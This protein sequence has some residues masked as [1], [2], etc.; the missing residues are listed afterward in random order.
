MKP[1]KLIMNAF[2]SYASRQEVDFSPLN[3]GGLFLITGPTGAGKTT[4]FDAMTFA[5]FGCASSEARRQEGLKSQYVSPQEEC[6][7]EFTFQ[8]GSQVYTVH[9]RPRQLRLNR[10]GAES[11]LKHTAALTLP[12]GEILSGAQAV[13][14]KIVELLGLNYQQFK[15]IVLLAQGEFRRLL[16]SNSED[17]QRIF[18]RIFGTQIFAELTQRLE[19]EEKQL[20]NQLRDYQTLSA[21]ALDALVQLGHTQLGDIEN[22]SYADFKLIEPIVSQNMT[23]MEAENSA[24]LQVIKDAEQKKA[25]IDLETAAR[26]NRNFERLAY[27]QET[28]A[29]LDSQQEEMQ[30]LEARLETIRAS[31]H[32][33][34][35]E[36]GLQTFKE[37]HR[38]VRETYAEQLRCLPQAEKDYQQALSGFQT[39]EHLE[40][41]QNDLLKRHNALHTV[42]VL[43]E[44]MQTLEREK[45]DLFKREQALEQNL[46]QLMRQMQYIQSLQAYNQS[47][48]LKDI[49]DKICTLYSQ[50]KDAQRL[51]CTRE[52]NY[53]SAYRRHLRGQASILASS[54]SDGKPCPV[55]GSLHHPA[56]S[57]QQGD[58]PDYQTVDRLKEQ[59]DAA[60]GHLRTLH[61]QI[62][63]LYH[64]LR[65]LDEQ[66]C[67]PEQMPASFDKMWDAY[68]TALAV[69]C[70]TGQEAVLQLAQ[71]MESIPEQTH[72]LS[73]E[74]LQMSCEN[75][76]RQVDQCRERRE[77]LEQRL[78]EQRGRIPDSCSTLEITVQ[79]IQK[80]EQETE[81]LKGTI[82]QRQ[83]IYLK[84]QSALQVLQTEM[85]ATADHAGQ[86]EA[87]MVK[88]EQRFQRALAQSG[89]DYPAYQT[90]AGE[91]STLEQ[92]VRQ[93]EDFKTSL[94]AVQNEYKVLK[95]Q[96][97]GRQLADLEMLRAQLTQLETLL[98]E[99]RRDQAQLFARLQNTRQRFEE[100]KNIDQASRQ[101]QIRYSAVAALS[102]TAK[103]N[104]ASKVS[105]ERY[106][107]AS[108]FEDVVRMAN[109]HLQKMTDA[110]YALKRKEDR[111]RRQPSG[112]D[113]EIIDSYTGQERHVSTLSGGE[114]FK[115]SFSLALGLAD[116]VQMHSGGVRVETMFIDEGFGALDE[117]S[118]DAAIAALMSLEENGRIVGIISHVSELKERI[119]TQLEVSK[120]QRGS[121]LSF[122][123]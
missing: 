17:K 118:L 32:L 16:D 49:T 85:K 24:L 59:L 50:I 56:P 120:S 3:A 39:I 54:L 55:C 78:A 35:I 107:L 108:Y 52:E 88:M 87:Q 57:V 121:T 114:S 70:R 97:Q 26:D 90:A 76:R 62:T 28:L 81:H 6:F 83:Q 9:R 74:A 7:V 23:A 20:R 8:I 73:V 95:T 46:T 63:A 109:I 22:F 48:K 66:A 38:S 100:L 64:Q 103:G 86:L 40:K 94:A 65:G 69:R 75:M 122:R 80:I 72:H 71:Q 14:Q 113:L 96:T 31:S 105:F 84:A 112:L 21:Y 58:I 30:R 99:K 101:L 92:C 44:E 67:L 53:L 11:E 19:D 5:L 110:R 27:L 2:E 102:Q 45:A 123:Y 25:Q 36:I 91:I 106:I 117:Q 79:Q 29:R 115:A 1:L 41:Q 61:D 37:Q 42:K 34:E 89:L 10:K 119:P 51:Y 82:Y 15:Q 68:R 47:V 18:S 4:I 33:K 104:N 13:D 93:T 116:I 77:I 12:N 98:E 60:S 111:S 43:F